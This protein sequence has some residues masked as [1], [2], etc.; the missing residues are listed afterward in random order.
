MRG[1]K[2]L[3]QHWHIKAGRK[4]AEMIMPRINSG[5]DKFTI[6]VAGESGS[7]KSEI[8]EVI[9]QTLGGRG[10]ESVILQQDDYFVLPPHSNARKREEDISWVGMEEVKLD[11]LDQNLSDFKAGKS[12]ITKPL[13][14]F[15]E[16]RIEQEVIPV[17]D[18]GV[19]IAEGTYTTGL[20]NVDCHVFIDRNYRETKKA[21]QL[22]GRDKQDDYLDKILEIEH[23]IISSHKPKAH[24][25][26][27]R[28]YEVEKIE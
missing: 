18:V 17:G 11:L 28:D 13:V 27:T 23:G 20:E 12:E 10:I 9:A 14:I 3:I 26:V 21:R 24:I 2:I 5:S 8:A 22:R 4:V 7:G 1:D 16:D 6:T 15:E 19:A 25:I